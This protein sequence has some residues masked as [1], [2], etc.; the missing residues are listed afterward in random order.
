MTYCYGKD[1]T[2]IAPLLRNSRN[3][4]PVSYT[5]LEVEEEPVRSAEDQLEL[6]QNSLL[7]ILDFAK[8]KKEEQQEIIT[9]MNA[10]SYTHL[11]RIH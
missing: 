8:I 5:H 4:T 10:V 6:L 3:S 9:A 11:L 7:Q 2:R 1:D